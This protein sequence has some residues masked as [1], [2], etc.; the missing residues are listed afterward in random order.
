MPGLRVIQYKKDRATG[1]KATTRQMAPDRPGGTVVLSHSADYLETRPLKLSAEHF[2][3]PCSLRELV[4]QRYAPPETT[5]DNEPPMPM[6]ELLQ[7]LKNIDNF[8]LTPLEAVLLQT[9]AIGDPALPTME[10]TATLQW[11]GTALHNWQQHFPLEQP[12]ASQLRQLQSLAAALA[13][14]DSA[15]LIPG[16]HPIHRLLDTLQACA[17]GWQSRLG[18]AGVATQQQIT[19][20][21]DRALAWF[22]NTGTDLEAIYGELAAVAQRD[23][24]RAGRMT[25]RTVETEQGRIKTADARRQAARMINTALEKFQ[26]TEAIGDFLKGP[27]YA[28]AQLVALKYGSDSEEWEK[29]SVTT[30][31]LL[32]SLQTVEEPAENRRQYIF[33]VVTQLPKDIRRLLLSLQHD[34]EAVEDAVGLIEFTHLQ[35]LRNQVLELEEIAAIDVGSDDAAERDR[36]HVDALDHVE[37]GQWWRIDLGDGEPLRLQLALK[38][39]DEQQL[40][41]TN[42]AGLK[43]LRQ[44]YRDFADLLARQ[45]VTELH[46][47]ASFSASLASAAGIDSIEQLEILA[48]ATA[49]LPGG[50]AVDDPTQYTGLEGID[51]SIE[52]IEQYAVDEPVQ[53]T[54]QEAPDEPAPVA[55]ADEDLN[56][57]MGTWLGFH[58]GDKPLMAKLAAHDREKGNYIFVNRKGIKILQL[59]ET[60]LLQ[61]VDDGLVDILQTNSTFRDRV[62][63]AQRQPEE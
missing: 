3:L 24:A 7:Y 4:L 9:E 25:Q 54:R 6:E 8:D 5:A 37:V 14:T 36:D 11:L 39:E 38:L 29:M 62:T 12:L 61:M 55:G 63:Q 53:Q 10:Q 2:P 59:S 40:L 17:I 22:D 32:D 23:Q 45:K 56:L 15:F 51:D 49:V 18:R 21:I 60:V 47:G 20:T 58:D 41:F 34:S 44:S 42:Q 19:K 27:W 43:A 1:D 35:V 28:S 13:V 33:E 31:T 52:H 46:C 26:A 48:D 30:D 57:P 50:M 16:A